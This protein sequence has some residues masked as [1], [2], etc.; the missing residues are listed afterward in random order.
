VRSSRASDALKFFGF[1]GAFIAK[2]IIIPGPP[3]GRR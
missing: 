2:P 3:P 1:V